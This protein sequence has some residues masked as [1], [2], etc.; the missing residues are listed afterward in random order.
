M[1]K[2][3]DDREEGAI[4]MQRRRELAQLRVRFRSDTLVKGTYEARL[5]DAGFA[6]HQHDAT[7]A[8]LGL[9]P[10]TQQ[11]LYFL[12]TPDDRQVRGPSR[13]KT[14]RDIARSQHLPDLLRAGEALDLPGPQSA[15]LE[16]LANLAVGRCGN[17]HGPRLG[18]GLQP[19]GEVRRIAQNGPLS[20]QALAD[21]VDDN[22]AGRNADAR[23]QLDTGAE[24]QAADRADQR[25]PGANR[26]LRIVLVR[27]RVAEIDQDAVTNVA[28]NEG[29]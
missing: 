16:Q 19:R 4:V 13:G 9:L 10:T 25:Q 26:P 15:A 8:S 17:Q 12:G 18:K 29:A 14:V 6:A 21:R 3:A 11:Q 2:L 20:R 1:L 22:K 5:S 24:L 27:R 28:R 23:V 7:F